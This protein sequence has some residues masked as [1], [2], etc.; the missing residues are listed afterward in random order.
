[1]MPRSFAILAFSC[2][3]ALAACGGGGGGGL[4]PSG[5]STPTPSATA[6]PTPKATATPTPASTATPTPSGTATPTP[7]S[8]SAFTGGTKTVSCAAAGCSIGM[9]SADNGYTATLTFGANNATS[10]FNLTMSWAKFSEITGT[11][12]PGALPTSIGTAVLYLDLVS[13]SSVSFTAT[14]AV[15]VSG[16][17]FPGTSCGFAFYGVAGSGTGGSPTWNGMTA[18]GLSEVTP[19]G[20]SFTVPSTTLPPGNTVQFDTSDQYIALYCH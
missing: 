18:I 20:G 2:A 12:A 19:S 6:T 17:S 11:F 5:N 7:S 4:T 9:P 10:N 3:A 13:A 14:P 1:M 16:A 15:S 8:S